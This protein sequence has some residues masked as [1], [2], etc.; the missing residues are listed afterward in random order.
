MK[1]GLLRRCGALGG[2]F[3]L[4][5]ESKLCSWQNWNSHSLASEI[6]EC[7]HISSLHRGDQSP[8]YPASHG[9]SGRGQT[10]LRCGRSS[11]DERVQVFRVRLQGNANEWSGCST[12]WKHK[13]TTRGKLGVGGEWPLTD[14]RRLTRTERVRRH[15]RWRLRLGGGRRSRSP[16][17]RGTTA[18]PWRW[19]L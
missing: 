2:W 13:V 9:L 5:G 11:R 16:G 10:N 3:P 7:S 1:S 6:K 15:W 17:V 19:C 12:W 18:S 4:C 14:L 8:H